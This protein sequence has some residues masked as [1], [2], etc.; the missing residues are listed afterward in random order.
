M[1]NFALESKT[2]EIFLKICDIVDSIIIIF[3]YLT[4]D[5][6][7]TFCYPQAVFY[8]EP[9]QIGAARCEAVIGRAS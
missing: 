9:I 5:V 3:K 1:P 7:S 6:A 4:E 2:D 8:V